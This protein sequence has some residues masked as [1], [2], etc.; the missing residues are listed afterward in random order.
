VVPNNI[1]EIC[2]FAQKK[3]YKMQTKKSVPTPPL[4]TTLKNNGP[5]RHAILWNLL[6]LNCYLYALS[7]DSIFPPLVPILSQQNPVHPLF[8]SDP[9]QYYKLIYANINEVI[10]S[11]QVSRLKLC[12]PVSSPMRA[13]GA[14]ISTSLTWLS[15]APATSNTI[16]QNG[17]GAH[18][19]S[20]PTGTGDSFPGVGAAGSWGWPL[21]SI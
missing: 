21:T 20:Y 17:S 1:T 10:S 2:V 4:R 8:I 7:R 19:A 16:V 14:V 6:Q 13:T 18:P 15:Q 12:K 5:V 9:N 11:F 3:T